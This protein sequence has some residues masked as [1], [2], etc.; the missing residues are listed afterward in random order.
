MKEGIMRIVY[1]IMI[2]M[3]LVSFL[4]SVLSI[5]LSASEQENPDRVE[6]SP[7]PLY[8]TPEKEGLPQWMRVLTGQNSVR[9]AELEKRIKE[10]REAA[11]YADAVPLAEEVLEIR[12]Q[13]QG[14]D[15]WETAS[16]E[17]LRR[18]LCHIASLPAEGQEA[19]SEADIAD[20][21]IS[22]LYV[23]WDFD[24]AFEL[25]KWQLEVRKHW[26][27]VDHLEV[28]RTM[29][30][31]AELLNVKED[32]EDGEQ[33]H[34]ETL[35]IKRTLLGE[36]HPD[37][38]ITLHNLGAL[39]RGK[40]EYSRSEEM[41]RKSQTIFR[42]I[43]PCSHLV[44]V[45]LNNLGVLLLERGDY[46]SAEPLLREALAIQRML[47]GESNERV[48][49]RLSNLASVFLS[50]GD[51]R[52]TEQLLQQALTM[53]RQDLGGSHPRV[54]WILNRIGNIQRALGDLEAVERSHC[55]AFDVLKG[56]TPFGQTH[57]LT[58]L[59]LRQ[60]GHVMKAKGEYEKAKDLFTE[61]L[62]IRRRHPGKEPAHLVA[63]Y[64]MDLGS[65][66]DAYGDLE[67]AKELYREALSEYSLLL[68][69]GHP[70]TVAT[71]NVLAKLH[72][73]EGDDTAAES[74]WSKAAAGFEYA[75]R[76]AAR[77]GLDRA[78]FTAERSPLVPL[79][80]CLA[81]NG[82]ALEAWHRFET[83][84][85]R[86]VLD[87]V[88]SRHTRPLTDEERDWEAN[89][90]GRLTPLEERASTLFVEHSTA[91]THLRLRDIQ[92]DLQRCQ[93]ELTQFDVEL[94][95]KYGVTAG[96]VYELEP[97]QSNLSGDATL[98]AWVD[99]QA[100]PHAVNPNGEHW[101]CVVSDT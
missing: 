25:A 55:N 95:E 68:G 85:A 62:K 57:L 77:S 92:S 79:A 99:L 47:D 23:A 32:R 89:I 78:H 72:Y 18:T 43:M 75:R 54:L 80:A 91:Q 3:C 4:S 29:N 67:S 83:N 14:T 58:A 87:A 5:P 8:S 36:E 49:S 82:Q 1:C 51:Y 70:A 90:I 48:A 44:A 34:L 7:G 101:A 9:V 53:L 61:A 65:S 96:E 21:T 26:L 93:T 12:R 11:R 52:S 38:G 37:V 10:L 63:H 45:S 97:I 6:Q 27:G 42:R 50:R 71:L 86:G 100:H 66:F 28:T 13:A 84:L 16:A 69:D 19:L 24:K 64:V 17:Q 88:S 41:Y 40:G 94:A 76:R 60:L 33:L 15:H 74:L 30:I 20:S 35:A 22:R 2:V 73:A 56:Y 98:L 46:A 81:R 31:L 59:S 39:L